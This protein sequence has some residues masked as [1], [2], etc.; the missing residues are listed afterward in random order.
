MVQTQLLL[1]ILRVV[2]LIAPVFVIH[3]QVVNRPEIRELSSNQTVERTIKRGE[4]HRYKLEL[5]ANEYL[6]VDVDQRGIDVQL[7]LLGADNQ[8]ILNRDRPNGARGPESLSFVAIIAGKYTLEVQAL[9]EN[10]EAGQY[11]LIRTRPRR[12]ATSLD[13][14]RVEAEAVFQDGA[15]LR[16]AG[17][18]ESVKEACDKFEKSAVLWR[19]LGDQYAEALTLQTLGYER[20]LLGEFEQ[21]TAAQERALSLYETL[22][23]KPDEAETLTA[24]CGLKAFLQEPFRALEY[25]RRA[26][27]LYRELNDVAKEKRLN[28]RLHRGADFSLK[29]AINLIKK[30]EQKS[31]SASVSYFLNVQQLYREL[32]EASDEALAL[33]AAA[34]STYVIGNQR[35]SLEYYKEALHPLRAADDKA[36]EAA[37][38]DIIGGVYELLNEKSI[39]LDYYDQ[40]LHV[41]R[42]IR[43]KD[44]RFAEVQILSRIGLIHNLVGT[45]SKALGFLDQALIISRD[46]GNWRSAEALALN[47]IGVIHKTTN[48]YQNA[49]VYFNKVIAL[50]E[51]NPDKEIEASTVNNLGAVYDDLGDKQQALIYCNKALS[52][53]QEIKSERGQAMTLN[54]IGEIYYSM[55]RK[56]E[57][58]KYYDQAL[59]LW[60]DQATKARVLNNIGKAYD[61]LRNRERARKYYE[62]ALSL[63]KR[64]GDKSTEATILS[65]MGI[66]YSLQGKKEIALDYFTRALPLRK[67]VGDKYGEVVT[68]NSLTNLY[69]LSNPRLAIFCI[70][71][72]V[73]IL[74]QLRL[75][76]Q[77]RQDH[78]PRTY[79][80][81]VEAAHRYLAQLL[82]KQGRLAEALQVLNAL[83]DQQYFDS[84]QKTLKKPGPI[85]M[86]RQEAALSS[87]YEV[88]SS[89]V[90][91]LVTQ[92]TQFTLGNQILTN[93]EQ[94]SLQQLENQ[95][96]LANEELRALFSRAELEFSSNSATA[97]LLPNKAHL[98][99]AAVNP[100]LT[101][102]SEQFT[103]NPN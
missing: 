48:D 23:S 84:D 55:A 62:E 92:I 56:E 68:F 20:E 19:E 83:K 15:L 97:S 102:N 9:E 39:A 80:R 77:G 79:L 37:D 81:S 8:T 49:L 16:R 98:R 11:G 31:Y 47:N 75:G 65:N 96:N 42:E 59:A 101:T 4:T 95:L 36:G 3:A 27:E 94:N 21:A 26:R 61:D 35:K 71:Q 52:L 76:M 74:Q 69:E 50:L 45:K 6:H 63:T 12:A 54:N 32:G 43:N 25:F 58:L 87:Q 34:R 17:S 64:I 33:M 22:R 1:S 5:K 40:A 24:L 13:H 38:L 2:L 99:P 85:T 73:N 100:R 53:Y 30:D 7:I 10:V 103:V 93:E 82:M 44:A 66:A 14:K 29:A 18:A 72:S 78:L 89:K 57:A 90:A 28:E 46:I 88:T 86:T 91:D 41:Y 70:K 51:S 60:K 67:A